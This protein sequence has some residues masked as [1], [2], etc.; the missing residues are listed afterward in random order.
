M[1]GSGL[2]ASWP[3]SEWPVHASPSTVRKNTSRVPRC[4]E[5][6]AGAKIA[7]FDRVE[8]TVIPDQA[9]AAAA[10]M[11]GEVDWVDV[12]NNDWPPMMNAIAQSKVRHF[13]DSNVAIMR[14]NC[15]SR[16]RQACYS[17]AILGAVNQEIL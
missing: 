9:T 12:T 1:V 14:F 6:S 16:I 13:Q 8:W 4:V 17:Q 7:H 5:R 15:C 3:T 11:A 10:L 2:T